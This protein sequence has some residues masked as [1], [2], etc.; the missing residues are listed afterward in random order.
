MFILIQLQIMD[1]IIKVWTSR[2]GNFREFIA[3]ARYPK[4]D[5][6]PMQNLLGTEVD[7][8]LTLEDDLIMVEISIKIMIK[9]L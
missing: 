1:I 8:D 6:L 9:D 7:F 5:I 3:I 4:E 2:G